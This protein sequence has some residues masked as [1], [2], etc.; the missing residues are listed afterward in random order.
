[1]IYCGSGS[2][3]YFR[4]VL[5]LVPA[6]DLL[7]TVFQH[8]KNHTKSCLFNA[9]SSI[10]PRKLASIVIFDFLTFV[11]YVG[12]ESISGSG[13]GTGM[14]SGSGAA[15]QRVAVPAVPVPAPVPQHS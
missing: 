11:L 6:P 15:R 5:V 10:V 8:Q 3:S 4:K 14:Y 1:M 7:S 2:G 12:S 9:K 13:T